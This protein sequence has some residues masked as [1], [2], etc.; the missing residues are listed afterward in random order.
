M[1]WVVVE[2]GAAWTVL[3]EV[4]CQLR[5]VRWKSDAGSRGG[6]D[7]RKGVDE[8][9]GVCGCCGRRGG[10]EGEGGEEER[11]GEVHGGDGGVVCSGCRRVLGMGCERARD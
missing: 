3:K 9:R 8:G 5:A 6:K 1:D 4:I 7:G 2:D 10:E 11:V